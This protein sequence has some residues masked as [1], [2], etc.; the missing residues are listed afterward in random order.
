MNRRTSIA[1]RH[2]RRA[3]AIGLLLLLGACSTTS[4]PAAS[5]PMMTASSPSRSTPEGRSTL[6]E[7]EGDPQMT[8]AYW[9]RAD[10]TANVGTLSNWV[11]ANVPPPAV[12][13]QGIEAVSVGTVEPD[14]TGAVVVRLG[15]PST[16]LAVLHTDGPQ[17][18][19]GAPHLV[20][21]T[22]DS[23]TGAVKVYVDGQVRPWLEDDAAAKLAAV[24]LPALVDS[25]QHVRIGHGISVVPSAN[26]AAAEVGE[27]TYYDRVLTAEQIAAIHSD[28]P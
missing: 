8:V 19:D 12:G 11:H 14:G 2:M 4:E 18:R 23:T 22:L 5:W 3:H 21:L 6:D 10:L 28:G 16:G 24:D 1:S 7:L 26:D 13:P 9:I 25:L 15:G 20:A 27:I 17:I